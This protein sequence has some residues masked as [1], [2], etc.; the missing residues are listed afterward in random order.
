MPPV[1]IKAE[2]QFL[3][4]QGVTDTLRLRTHGAYANDPHVTMRLRNVE[5][6]LRAADLLEAVKAVCK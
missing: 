6:T 3:E 4:S 5:V 2:V 1:M